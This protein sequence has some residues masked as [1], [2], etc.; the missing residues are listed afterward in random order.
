MNYIYDGKIIGEMHPN[1]LEWWVCRIC[2]QSTPPVHSVAHLIVIGACDIKGEQLVSSP[3]LTHHRSGAVFCLL[4]QVS[5]DYARP[6]TGQVTEVTCP[7]IGRTQPEL[8]PEQET[9]YRPWCFYMKMWNSLAL[10]SGCNLK[11]VIFNFISGI[12]ILSISCEIGL[13]TSLMLSQHCFR[14]MR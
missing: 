7:V 2:W 5:S 11:S 1:C 8:T 12:G 10:E 4:L 13:K 14:Y 6:I 9:E 3:F